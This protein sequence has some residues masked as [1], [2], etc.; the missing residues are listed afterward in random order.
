MMKDPTVQSVEK[1]HQTLI[2]NFYQLKMRK[3]YTENLTK[4]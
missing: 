1:I 4:N 3:I 2:L